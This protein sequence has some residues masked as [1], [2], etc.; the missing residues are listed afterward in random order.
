MDVKEWL[1]SRAYLAPNAAASALDSDLEVGLEEK[2]HGGNAACRIVLVPS[3]ELLETSWQVPL[4]SRRNSYL[5]PKGKWRD[6]PAFECEARRRNASS[7]RSKRKQEINRILYCDA[8]CFVEIPL[9]RSVDLYRFKEMKFHSSGT[10]EPLEFVGVL[11]SKSVRDFSKDNLKYSFVSEWK[12]LHPKM[13][14]MRYRIIFNNL[15]NP[16]AYSLLLPSE[17]YLVQGVYLQDILQSE[18]GYVEVM[19]VSSSTQIRFLTCQDVNPVFPFRVINNDDEFSNYQGK[20]TKFLARNMIQLDD[21]VRVAFDAKSQ[22]LETVTIG[23]KICFFNL[24]PF[25]NQHIPM[26]PLLGFVANGYSSIVIHSSVLY[27]KDDNQRFVG[28]SVPAK[29]TTDHLPGVYSLKFY[30]NL[31]NLRLKKFSDSSSNSWVESG[32]L[33]RLSML[34]EDSDRAS[35]CFNTYMNSVDQTSFLRSVVR[36]VHDRTFSI[37]ALQFLKQ[38]STIDDV[39]KSK[40]YIVG[41][42]ERSSTNFFTYWCADDTK[43]ISLILNYCKQS[44]NRPE[45]ISICRSL[46]NLYG[47]YGSLRLH[48]MFF[49]NSSSFYFASLDKLEV[50][51]LV[52]EN[53]KNDMRTVKGI[54][55]MYTIIR[56]AKFYIQAKTV[57]RNDLGN[58]SVELLLVENNSDSITPVEIFHDSDFPFFV[59]GNQYIYD[60]P[61]YSLENSKRL[62]VD[63]YRNECKPIDFKGPRDILTVRNSNKVDLFRLSM[64]PII[65][66]DPICVRGIVVES[67][68]LLLD[69]SILELIKEYLPE[70]FTPSGMQKV[71]IAQLIENKFICPHD[72]IELY[73]IYGLE[74]P[75]YLKMNS[76]VQIEN[77]FIFSSWKSLNP[78]LVGLSSIVNVFSDCFNYAE[79]CHYFHHH[80]FGSSLRNISNQLLNFHR[81]FILDFQ[82]H[83]VIVKISICKSLWIWFDNEGDKKSLRIQSSLVVDDG[84]SEALIFLSDLDSFENLCSIFSEDSSILNEVYEN[85]RLLTSET[86]LKIFRGASSYNMDEEAGHSI[87]IRHVFFKIAIALQQMESHWSVNSFDFLYRLNSNPKLCNGLRETLQLQQAIGAEK[88][89]FLST[90]V[91]DKKLNFSVDNYVRE[92]DLLSPPKFFIQMLNCKPVRFGKNELI[93]KLYADHLI[94]KLRF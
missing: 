67:S 23:I 48:N 20:V 75:F 31:V 79:Q 90:I 41:K 5:V 84:T 65:S 17:C 82:S 94:A 51:T 26:Q 45:F 56:N 33:Q 13:E 6:V 57:I 14:Q 73:Y 18:S 61:I 52:K 35:I 43:T 49:E 21:K 11:V 24:Y 86:K 81:D 7:K 46:R 22:L 85:A 89:H 29:Y 9:E 66:H 72:R 30:A 59:V 77:L 62:F 37:P 64:F 69:Q 10:S 2:I 32:H 28:A 93:T 27:A 15:E 58:L 3:S 80:P 40:I 25:F 53:N 74:G 36:E 63:L 47:T 87:A 38:L 42:L 44:L 16:W 92:L 70:R 12:S 68:Q 54:S 39:C 8:G 76:L 83:R 19:S 50:F 34:E 55:D 1:A 71:I 60:G 78:F 88:D 91:G 4:N